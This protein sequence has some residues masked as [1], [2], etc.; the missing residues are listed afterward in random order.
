MRARL[1]SWRFPVF[2]HLGGVGERLWWREAQRFQR[3]FWKP[4]FRYDSCR[5]PF[6]WK[7]FL[8]LHC[9]WEKSQNSLAPAARAASD[10]MPPPSVP[11]SRPPSVTYICHT[12]SHHGDL[13]SAVTSAWKLVSSPLSRGKASSP[14][15]YQP[16]MYLSL[17][18]PRPCQV[19]PL[20]VLIATLSL[21]HL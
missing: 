6:W 2:P 8:G 20:L 10:S 16:S 18:P 5:L 14:S 17:Q 11:A 13:A 21:S 15:K 9:L 12:F 4:G 7:H 1:P 19:F 3:C